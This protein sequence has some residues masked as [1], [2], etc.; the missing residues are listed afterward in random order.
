MKTLFFLLSLLFFIQ[1]RAGE[2]T[3]AG[4][5]VRDI[6]EKHNLSVQRLE[7]QGYRLLLGEVTGAGGRINLND[8][9]LLLTKKELFKMN[10]LTHIDFIFPGPAKAIQDV[11]YFEFDRERLVPGKIKAIVVEK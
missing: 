4:S 10:D 5:I 2:V 3:G 6:L 9:K 7:S 8:V 1:L 11:R